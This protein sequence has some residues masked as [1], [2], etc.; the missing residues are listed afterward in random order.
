MEYKGYT[1]KVAFDEKAMIL[2]GEVAGINDVVTFQAS[3]TAD[4]V[5]AF[6]DSVDDYLDFCGEE[7]VDP[8]KPYSGNFIV[9]SD[10]DLHRQA[11]LAAATHGVSINQWVISAIRQQLSRDADTTQ[12]VRTAK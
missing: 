6:H 1:A 10:G 9:R 7:G 4:F 8:E 11:A 12:P 2:H 5:T 3:N